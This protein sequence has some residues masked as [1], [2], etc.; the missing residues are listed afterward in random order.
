MLCRYIEDYGYGFRQYRPCASRARATCIHPTRC[1]ALVRHQTLLH[2]SFP[3]EISNGQTFHVDT[4]ASKPRKVQVSHPADSRTFCRSNFPKSR[5]FNNFPHRQCFVPG[6]A[7]RS[8]LGANRQTRNFKR[9]HS[10]VATSNFQSVSAD[11]TQQPLKLEILKVRQSSLRFKVSNLRARTPSLGTPFSA[12]E[13]R[14][15]KAGETKETNSMTI[16]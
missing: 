3:L 14:G 8:A 1:R 6:G 4:P 12:M 15:F 10:H 16:I 7:P 11:R 9:S 13:C 2:S 5:K